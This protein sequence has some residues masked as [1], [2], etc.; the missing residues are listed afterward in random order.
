MSIPHI[1]DS[2]FVVGKQIARGVY[3]I[4]FQGTDRGTNLPVAIKFEPTDTDGAQLSAEYKALQIT[5][6]TVGVPRVCHFGREGPYN[7]LVTDQLGPGLVEL[8]DKCGRRFS[9]KTVCMVAVQ[10]VGTHLIQAIHKKG[11][12]HRYLRP[13]N[14][15]LGMPESQEAQRIHIIAF[16]L[17]K[18]YLDPETGRHVPYNEGTAFYGSAAFMSINAHLGREQSRRDDLESIGYVLIYFLRNTLPWMDSKDSNKLFYERI[19][20]QMQTTSV[21]DLCAG[22]PEEFCV[23]FRYI[24][25]LEFEQD[26]DYD[27]LCT[28]FKNILKA[29]GEEDD[30]VYDWNRRDEQVSVCQALPSLASVLIMCPGCGILK[31]GM[32]KSTL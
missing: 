26:P 1:I 4:V 32:M 15:L 18:R 10:M 11:L 7:V 14:F 9:M 30:G 17:A 2:R 21:P 20:E 23:Y 5:D 22:L 6:G 28:L 16:G 19:G 27:F 3:S 24:R 29:I 25:H 12:V 8:F 13:H 31:G